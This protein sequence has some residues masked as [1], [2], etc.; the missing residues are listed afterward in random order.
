[1]GFLGSNLSRFSA[2]LCKYRMVLSVF[3]YIMGNDYGKYRLII[4]KSLQW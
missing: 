1:M 4:P 3:G 2:F